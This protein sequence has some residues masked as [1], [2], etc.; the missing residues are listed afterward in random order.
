M[1]RWPEPNQM[2]RQV[3]WTII[4]IVGLVPE[5]DSNCHW[6][7]LIERPNLLQVGFA[8]ATGTTFA[9]GS[10]QPPGH[11]YREYSSNHASCADVRS[12]AF[13]LLTFRSA[14]WRSAV[15]PSVRITLVLHMPLRTS[16]RGAPN[17]ERNIN[18]RLCLMYLES[19]GHPRQICT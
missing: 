10:K 4:A 1:R 13:I 12:A 11:S 15:V 7:Q 8:L 3:Y 14:F 18:R 19:R 2:W 6:C 5:G 17:R 9:N 16:K